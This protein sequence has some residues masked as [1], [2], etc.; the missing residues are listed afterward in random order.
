[1]HCFTS[2]YV[3][4]LRF[5]DSFVYDHDINYKQEPDSLDPKFCFASLIPVYDYL[6][7]C[8]YFLPIWSQGNC[9]EL[10][11]CIWSGDLQTCCHKSRNANHRPRGLPWCL[12]VWA[13]FLRGG[14]QKNNHGW[15]NENWNRSGA[16]SSLKCFRMHPEWRGPVIS[17]LAL[18]WYRSCHYP[19]WPSAFC[20]L[21]LVSIKLVQWS[22]NHNSKT[23][24]DGPEV[25]S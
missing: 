22:C 3:H 2:A 23:L 15:G 1:M 14:I 17:P 24:L 21:V 8:N 9:S 20:H 11:Y 4:N 18:S 12:E 13:Q 16:G 25:C 10:R 5:M 19:P 6:C 7:L